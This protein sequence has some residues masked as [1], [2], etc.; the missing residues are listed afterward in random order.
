MTTY[1]SFLPC[2][3]WNRCHYSPPFVSSNIKL[4]KAKWGAQDPIIVSK[5]QCLHPNPDFL[6]A[7]P[8]HWSY[9]L[10]F[11]VSS[12]L[13]IHFAAQYLLDCI[14]LFSCYALGIYYVPGPAWMVHAFMWAVYWQDISEI[15]TRISN[16]SQ[17]VINIRKGQDKFQE[18]AREEGHILHLRVREVRLRLKR[19]PGVWMAS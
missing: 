9:T 10:L 18:Q 7:I 16:H 3:I 13:V 19:Q 6:T 8:V 4:R 12:A 5:L 2:H 1:K 15:N 17:I 11:L 14:H